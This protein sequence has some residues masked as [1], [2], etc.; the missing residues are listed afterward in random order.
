MRLIYLYACKC[1]RGHL[2]ASRD[3]AGCLQA[4]SGVSST[5]NSRA[6][7]RHITTS[8]HTNALWLGQ[9]GFTWL[10]S[11]PPRPQ[12]VVDCLRACPPLCDHLEAHPVG[13][14]CGGCHR[15]TI[16]IWPSPHKAGLWH[17]SLAHLM[18][19]RALTSHSIYILLDVRPDC[20]CC[21]P[22]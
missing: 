7:P 8:L 21:W 12:F 15:D 18:S 19:F 4:I 5:A 20:C 17:V 11:R 3:L 9:L 10:L 14:H 2:I 22:G 13:S 1:H 16:I 6:S